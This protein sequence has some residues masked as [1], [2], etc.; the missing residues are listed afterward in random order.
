MY[1]KHGK[2]RSKIYDR[3]SAI[4]KRCCNENSINYSSYGGRG[5][6]ICERWKNSFENFYS[7]MGDPPFSKAEI[8][9]IDNDGDYEPGN[10]RWVTR[11]ENTRNSTSVK[12]TWLEVNEIRMISFTKSI[13]VRELSKIYNI[14]PSVISEISN[15]K[16][17]KIN[18][19]GVA[20]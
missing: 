16:T 6:K 11:A 19:G 9:R 17:W 12:L 18:K 8:D 1:F 4:K 3:W 14:S 7:D 2:A 15:N 20:C 5:I 13:S 10:C